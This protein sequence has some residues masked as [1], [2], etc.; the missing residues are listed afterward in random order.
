MLGDENKLMTLIKKLYQ[1]WNKLRLV[2]DH[3]FYPNYLRN[4]GV[5]IGENSIILYPS[6]VDAR[7][8]YLVE[9]GSNV[10]IS[11]N[12]TILTHD[13]AT[14]FA[15][16]MIKVGT[17]TIGDNCFIGANC[18][19]LCGVN[20]GKNTI[21]GAG[22]VVN[23]DIPDGSVYGGNPIRHICQTEKFIEKHQK[24][25]QVYPF[26]EGKNFE[27][28]YIDINKKKYLKER[29]STGFGYFCATLPNTKGRNISAK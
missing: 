7:L 19:V 11:L 23:R 6:Y 28:P 29:L 27:S 2:V 20:I 4:Q 13:S 5:K 14:A 16:D 25:G 24:W 1:K 9:I 26:F 12:S 18:T 10:V 21:I 8:P 22:S 15:G 17:V 3:S